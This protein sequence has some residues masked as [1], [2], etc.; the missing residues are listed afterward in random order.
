MVGPPVGARGPGG[1]RACWLQRAEPWRPE[2]PSR[3]SLAPVD[4]A[5]RAVHARIL[6]QHAAIRAGKAVQALAAMRAGA[7]T[8][9]LGLIVTVV[10]IRV[11]SSPPGACTPRTTTIVCGAYSVKDY[12]RNRAAAPDSADRG[13]RPQW[14][15]NLPRSQCRDQ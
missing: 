3:V 8:N 12:F 15:G 14:P 7:T 1:P 13:A 4:L 6:H 10:D 9:L 11:H 5:R 2:R